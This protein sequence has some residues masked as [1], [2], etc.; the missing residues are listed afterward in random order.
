[1]SLLLEELRRRESRARIITAVA[2]AAT[3]AATPQF[4]YRGASKFIARA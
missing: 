4:G 2:I 3:V 1:M